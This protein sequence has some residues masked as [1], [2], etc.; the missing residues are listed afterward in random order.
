MEIAK[1]IIWPTT[2]SNNTK[3]KLIEIAQCKT[4]FTDERQIFSDG[5]CYIYQGTAAICMQAKNLKTVNHMVM[6]KQEWFGDCQSVKNNLL[7]FSLSEVE[8]LNFIFF[9]S[10][11]LNHLMETDLEVV[12]WLY[13]VVNGSQQKWR[14]SQL[15]SSENKLI[16]ISYLLIELAMHQKHIKGVFPKIAISQQTTSMI[17][18][19]ARQRV[20]E[21]L[22]QLESLGYIELERNSV[23]ITDFKGLCGTLDNVDL[24]IRD[25]RISLN[26]NTCE[27]TAS[28]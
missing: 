13:H 28:A 6:G 27:L 1:H 4:E 22:K 26:T 9:P 24:S 10:N 11:Q 12:K 20:N 3:R 21:A 17:L 25:P 15:L 7:S 5:V 16:K 19:I 2:L 8:P 14:Q 18:G 23:Y